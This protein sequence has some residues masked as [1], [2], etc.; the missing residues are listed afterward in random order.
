MKH[1]RVCYLGLVGPAVNGQCDVTGLY[2]ARFGQPRP[3]QKIFVVTCQEKNGWK[4]QDMVASAVVPST[5]Q[6][7]E[8][9]A[10]EQPPTATAAAPEPPSP[11]QSPIASH[12]S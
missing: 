2:T 3:G 5:S 4:A 6:P 1:R 12:S 11:A 8:P 9:Q 7:G 10:A